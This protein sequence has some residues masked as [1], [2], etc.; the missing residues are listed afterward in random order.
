MRRCSTTLA[1]EGATISWVGMDVV[2]VEDSP[3]IAAQL[4]ERLQQQPSL[5]VVGQAGGEDAAVSLI[6]ESIPDAVILDLS[7][8]P[9][10]GLG[11]LNR[12]REAGSAASVLVLT[13]FTHQEIRNACFRAGASH[14][15]DKHTQADE[16]IRTLV[17][18][19][20]QREQSR[21]GS[22]G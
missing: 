12:I 17:E 6:L 2:L 11:V 8:Q 3:L 21:T 14:F 15:F 4:L 5:R 13:N 18:M 1:T 10:S 16:C 7:L 22:A 9:G 20:E 19:G